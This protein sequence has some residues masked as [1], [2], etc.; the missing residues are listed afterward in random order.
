MTQPKHMPG[1]ITS[2]VPSLAEL[3]QSDGETEQ[4][5]ALEGQG[6]EGNQPEI[7]AGG[8]DLSSPT[9]IHLL[10]LPRSQREL[11]RA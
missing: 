5:M 6:K 7:A 1:D 2:G 3:L 11:S 9:L 10:I 4:L 8:A